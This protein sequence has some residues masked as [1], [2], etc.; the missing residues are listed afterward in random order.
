MTET[1]RLLILKYSDPLQKT[2][3]VF[4]KHPDLDLPMDELK[5][6]DNSKQSRSKWGKLK[7]GLTLAY[8]WQIAM[9]LSKDRKKRLFYATPLSYCPRQPVSD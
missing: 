7:I 5:R 3:D 8:M 2:L 6:C 1:I 9:Q 4:C